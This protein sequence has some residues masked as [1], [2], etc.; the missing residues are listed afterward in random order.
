MSDDGPAFGNFKL[1]LQSVVCHRGNS[2]NSGHYVS[3]VRSKEQDTAPS[4]ESTGEKWMRLDD[5]AKERVSFVDAQQFLRKE[6]PYLLFYQVQLIDGDAENLSDI[7]RPAESEGPPSYAESESRDSGVADLS[8]SFHG[9][10]ET[11]SESQDLNGPSLL[12]SQE[13]CDGSS[14]TYERRHSILLAGTTTEGPKQPSSIPG[15]DPNFLAAYHEDSKL[16]LANYRGRPTSSPNQ[17]KRRMSRSLSRLAGK[18][19]KDKLS[20]DATIPRDV[21][22]DPPMIPQQSFKAGPAITAGAN[23]NGSARPK[24]DNTNKEKQNKW[25]DGHVGQLIKG[26]QKSDKPDRECE[27]M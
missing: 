18:L 25:T 27:I 4:N 6:S 20:D 23:P 7:W 14:I 19:T 1:S 2:V 3:L 13:R 24:K 8:L 5:L 22:D 17:D 26:K 11:N 12:T 10:Q 16:N 9:S 21:A 15:K